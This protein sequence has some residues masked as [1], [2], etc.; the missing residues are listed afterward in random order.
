LAGAPQSPACGL[1]N[2]TLDNGISS[3]I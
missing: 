1:D 2:Y 3:E